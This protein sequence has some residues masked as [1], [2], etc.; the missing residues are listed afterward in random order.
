MSAEEDVKKIDPK[1]HKK[2]AQFL[3]YS[4][5]HYNLEIFNRLSDRIG[6]INFPVLIELLNNYILNLFTIC[7]GN[8]VNLDVTKGI[9]DEAVMIVMDYISISQEDEFKEENYCP[10]YADAI[11]FS[12]QKVHDR[13]LSLIPL[14]PIAAVATN[15]PLGVSLST[16]PHSLPNSFTIPS[17]IQTGTGFTKSASIKRKNF[18]PGSA[19]GLANYISIIGGATNKTIKSILFTSEVIT[20][21]YNMISQYTLQMAAKS[22]RK[23]DSWFELFEPVV[24]DILKETQH[25]DDIQY[26][27]SLFFT[28]LTYNLDIIECYINM[29]LPQLLKISQS[30]INHMD[31]VKGIQITNDITHIY[32][33]LTQYTSENSQ[34]IPSFI[35]LTMIYN[36]ITGHNI[37]SN[38]VVMNLNNC[39]QTG[40]FLSHTYYIH[41]QTQNM[42]TNSGDYQHL[43]Q[44]VNALS[45]LKTVLGNN[46]KINNKNLITSILTLNSYLDSV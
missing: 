31:L 8:S 3:L 12:F 46:K 4:Y 7:V 27:N 24:I 23:P 20:R 6:H 29:I 11:H 18:S 19:S 25:E 43:K 30:L 33:R 5:C 16:S 40:V 45:Q 36:Y 1:K 32:Q 42:D 22:K 14:K 21:I 38:N 13:I 9:I 39:I 44:Y 2:Y 10:K 35:I 41:N 17:S 28:R 15:L 37:D 34:K 26:S